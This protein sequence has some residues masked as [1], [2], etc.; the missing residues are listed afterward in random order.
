MAG[1][2]P[3]YQM[4]KRYLTKDREEIWVNLSV[5]LV[6]DQDGRPRHFI[7][8]IED[9][10]ER[11]HAQTRLQQAELDRADRFQRDRAGRRRGALS[12]L[13]P[14]VWTRR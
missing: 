3:G 4:E 13:G 11:R 10:S 8:Q 6:R 14:S 2:I 7:S 5:S 1:E 9:I 12:V